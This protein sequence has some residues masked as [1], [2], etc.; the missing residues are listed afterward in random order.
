MTEAELTDSIR[1]S[2]P[3][4]AAMGLSVVAVDDARV[5]VRI[6]IDANR[7]DKGTLFAGASYSGLV[8]AGWT[9]AMHRAKASGFANPWVAVVDAKVHYAKPIRETVLATATFAE[10]PRLVPG[11][12]NWAQVRVTV[13]ARL[14]FE[15]RYAVGERKPG[16]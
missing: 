3:I 5:V 2:I 16:A 4:M 1:A 7:N 9:L 12:R 6:P 15:G 10:E 8:L 11:A 14:A 13:D